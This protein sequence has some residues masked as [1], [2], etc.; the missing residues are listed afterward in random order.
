MTE[1]RDEALREAVLSVLTKEDRTSL[2]REQAR[3]TMKEN[4][5]MILT[6]MVTKASA[7]TA[8]TNILNNTRSTHVNSQGIASKLN[9]NDTTT[10]QEF[11]EQSTATTPAQYVPTSNLFP[12]TPTSIA[13][14]PT[15][16]ALSKNYA[17]SAP[18]FDTP[19][20][21]HEP[22]SAAPPHSSRPKSATQSP[23]RNTKPSLHSAQNLHLVKAS[24]LA[25]ALLQSVPHNTSP[26]AHA[27]VPTSIPTRVPPGPTQVT[28]FTAPEKVTTTTHTKSATKRKIRD[29]KSV[30]MFQC[31][32]PVKRTV[33]GTYANLQ[34]AEKNTYVRKDS[35]LTGMSSLDCIFYTECESSPSQQPHF[36]WVS[37]ILQC[38]NKE[39]A[40]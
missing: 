21:V 37:I 33:L 36:F 31:Q 39:V 7:A 22:H 3:D 20:P 6:E 32:D 19:T 9:A 38:A 40:F 35:I 28:T 18:T 24:V 14:T 23:Q 4:D 29:S 13:G 30:R 12:S 2:L 16:I 34:L 15:A 11:P 8:A 1:S 10:T 25:H 27:L 26:P 17:L 5:T